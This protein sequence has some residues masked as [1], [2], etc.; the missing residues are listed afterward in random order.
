LFDLKN[1]AEENWFQP[2]ENW[3]LSIGLLADKMEIEKAYQPVI[4][5]EGTTQIIKDLYIEVFH[6][7][8]AE[9]SIVDQKAFKETDKLYLMAY[10]VIRQRK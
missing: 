6:Q 7:L 2:E 5:V 1:A 3:E 8:Y 10:S 9:K 4:S